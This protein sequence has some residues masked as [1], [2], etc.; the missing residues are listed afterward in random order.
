MTESE[1]IELNEILK[2]TDNKPELESIKAEVSAIKDLISADQQRQLEEKEALLQENAQK[3]QQNAELSEIEKAE[4]VEKEKQQQEFN[5]NV[6]DTL[7]QIDAHLTP[8]EDDVTN[9][10]LLN[11]LKDMNEN[12]STLIEYQEDGKEYQVN[13]LSLGTM[14]VSVLIIG[15]GAYFIFQ[16]GRFVV[17]KLVNIAFK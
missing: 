9:V 16:F 5:K 15:L 3:E 7:N 11:Q 14:T 2:V 8:S 13:Q 6:V 4:L 1:A 10:E 12:L 17:S